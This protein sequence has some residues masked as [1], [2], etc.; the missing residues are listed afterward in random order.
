MDIVSIAMSKR[1]GA[2]K[3]PVE[4]ACLIRDHGIQGNAHEG[5]GTD[6]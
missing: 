1:K 5:R 3:A 4:K 6:R 2:R